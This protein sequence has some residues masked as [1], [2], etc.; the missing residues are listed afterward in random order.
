MVRYVAFLRGMNLGNRRVRMEELR[1]HLQPLELERLATHGASG[2]VVFDAPGP[3]EEPGA[4]ERG[5]ERRLAEG[6]GYPVGTHVRSLTR[7]AELVATKAVAEAREE[8]FKPHVVFLRD[9]L[10][11]GGRKALTALET[12]D[13]AF[14]PLGREVVWLRRGGLSDAPISQREL[15]AA[16]GPE[17]TMRTLGTVERIV[18]KHRE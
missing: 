14:L 16:V 5:F 10:P 11:E 3:S 12:P 2:N 15:E 13:D 17:N 8:G 9:T 1:V 18:R 4:L 6:L 7:L